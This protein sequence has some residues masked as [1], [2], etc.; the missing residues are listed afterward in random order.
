M[1][2]KEKIFLLQVIIAQ[3]SLKDKT[4]RTNNNKNNIKTVKT[5]KNIN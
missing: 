1:M 3:I 5:S 2:K 4:K